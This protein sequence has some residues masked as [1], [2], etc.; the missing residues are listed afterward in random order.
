MITFIFYV[1]DLL[2]VPLIFIFLPCRE[3]VHDNS[4]FFRENLKPCRESRITT[5]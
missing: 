4:E 3:K 5:R 2:I 1:T